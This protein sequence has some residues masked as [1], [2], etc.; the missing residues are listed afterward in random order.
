MLIG[1]GFNAKA[2]RR[3]GPLRSGGIER[4]E[5]KT[6]WKPVL[7]EEGRVGVVLGVERTVVVLVAGD[8]RLD[9]ELST[10]RLGCG[11]RLAGGGFAVFVVGAFAVG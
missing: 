7:R 8:W 3:I 10:R 11:S 4:C 1:G 9:G 5:E 6:G 2:L